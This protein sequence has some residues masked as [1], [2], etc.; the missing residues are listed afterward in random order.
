MAWMTRPARDRD[1][2]PAHPVAC[3]QRCG[4]R[5]EQDRARGVALQVEARDALE[6]G[7]PVVAA[8]SH[9]V[10]EEREHQRVGERLRDDRQVDAGD[11]RSEREPSE[12]EREQ[13]WSEPDHQDREPEVVE[14]VPEPRQLGPVE[15]HHE[16]GQ[17][18][19]AVDATRADLA[20]QI[21]AH[22]VAAQREERGMP[23]AQ[24]AAVAPDEIDGERQRRVAEILADER[25]GVGREMQRRGLRA[26]R[27]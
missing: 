18:R 5:D 25:H 1:D 16:V 8:E 6:I 11:A 12:H 3:G 7:E 26:P 24:N 23:E 13:R 9:V 14:A 4:A 10:A 20:H 17:H 2:A 27:G 22:R 21:H 15:K 19:M